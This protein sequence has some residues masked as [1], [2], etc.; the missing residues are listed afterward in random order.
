MALRF[1]VRVPSILKKLLT[2]LH[3]TGPAAANTIY[4]TFDDGPLPELCPWILQCLEEHEALATFFLVG[5]NAARYPE[6]TGAIL[7]AGHRIGNHTHNHLN[8]F[9]T[10]GSDYLQ[11]TEASAE[12]LGPYLSPGFAP[13]FRPPYG[14]IR[15]AQIRKLRQKGYEIVLWDVLSK[16]YD[17]SLRADDVYAN[18]VNHVSPGSVI[19]FHDNLKAEARLK[20]AL[21]RILTE[22]RRQGY[23]FGV[24]EFPQH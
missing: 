11:N 5:E 23:R 19:V 18:V 20:S 10:A 22:L 24:L 6:L 4:L 13:L 14:R 15:P 9:Q 1:P 2:G 8:G 16:D 7:R 12:V 3:F 17:A 21:P